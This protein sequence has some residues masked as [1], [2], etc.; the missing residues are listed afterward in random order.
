MSVG[1][2]RQVAPIKLL[3]KAI[4]SVGLTDG[5]ALDDSFQLDRLLVSP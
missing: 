3:T 4:V 1:R 2:Q 5:P